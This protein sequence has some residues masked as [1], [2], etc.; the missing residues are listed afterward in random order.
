MKQLMIFA[1]M[2]AL[3]VPAMAENIRGVDIEFVTIGNPGNAGERQTEDW[4]GLPEVYYGLFAE[5]D[6][7]HQPTLKAIEYQKAAGGKG[8]LYQF[9][10]RK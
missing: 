1:A 4:G 9:V 3:A 10:N 2:V 5:P 6:R 8:D 7:G